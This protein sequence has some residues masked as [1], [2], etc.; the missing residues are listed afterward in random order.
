MPHT[1]T[2]GA[3]SRGM[4]PLR[5]APSHAATIVSGATCSY[6]RVLKLRRAE[7]QASEDPPEQPWI[8]TR[9]CKC[10]ILSKVWPL[11]KLGQFAERKEEYERGGEAVVN[12]HLTN[13][14][15]SVQNLIFPPIQRHAQRTSTEHRCV[16]LLFCLFLPLFLFL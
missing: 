5:A 9:S 14:S 3:S 11:C 13:T 15:F 16:K 7:H 2:R 1:S 4:L 8:N 10:K 6:W 12:S